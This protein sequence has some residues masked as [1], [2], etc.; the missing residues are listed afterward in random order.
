M[1][2]IIVSMH[3]YVYFVLSSAAEARTSIDRNGLSLI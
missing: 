2:L 3:C 1:A